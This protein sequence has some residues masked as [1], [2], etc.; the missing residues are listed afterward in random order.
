MS[1]THPHPP[2]VA[3]GSSYFG[4][5]FGTI[6]LA[7]LNIKEGGRLDVEAYRRSFEASDAVFVG[8]LLRKAHDEALFQNRAWCEVD[9]RVAEIDKT[10]FRSQ[11]IGSEFFQKM[12]VSWSFPEVQLICVDRTLEI[13]G[14]QIRL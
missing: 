11:Q 3:S 12:G 1:R 9:L 4:I 2:K 10:G 7:A 8:R 5:S 6:G 13:R 14:Q